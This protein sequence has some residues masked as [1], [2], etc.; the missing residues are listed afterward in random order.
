MAS[1]EFFNDINSIGNAVRSR[2][3]T[4]LINALGEQ[5]SLDSAPG[6]EQASDGSLPRDGSWVRQS[7][8]TYQTPLDERRTGVLLAP[9]DRYNRSFSTAILK[10]TDSS[11]GGN[12]MINPPPQ[13][14][15]Y[16][17]IH[18]PRLAGDTPEVG[19]HTPKN[20]QTLGQGRYYSESI[21][22]NSQ[23][24][25]M[26]FGIATFTSLTTFF[27]GFYSGNL[28]AMARGARFT[29]DFVTKWAT[30]VGNVI[31]L[32]ISPLFIVPIAIMMLGSMARFFM[33][34]PSSKFYTLKPAMPLYWN[35]VT[36]IVNQLAV[37]SGLS[38]Q[39][40]TDTAK[41]LLKGGTGTTDLKRNE[42]MNVVGQF[43][44]KGLL[45]NDGSINVYSIANRTNRMEMQYQKRLAEAF[46]NAAPD[47]SWFDVV[48][49][50]IAANPLDNFSD[51]APNFQNYMSRF[52]NFLSFNKVTST[53]DAKNATFEKDV[54]AK[55]Y[56]EKGDRYNGEAATPPGWSD[57]FV[58]N[59]NDGSEWVSYRVDYTGPA[60]EHFDNSVTE[61]S[62]ASK[63]NSM[64]RSSRD[65]RFNLA[66]GN[67]G[68]IGVDQVISA[69]R[70]VVS[71]IAET[72]HVEGLFALAGSAF[73]DIPKH[74]NE[75]SGSLNKSNY[76]ITL[77]SPYGNP[78]SRLFNIWLPLATLLAGALPLATGKQSHTS[79]FL[80]EL[81]DR[82]RSISRLAIVDSMTITRGTSNLGFD[83]EGNAMAIEVSFSVLDLSSVVAMPIHAGFDI[84]NP[85]EGLFDDANAF[86]DYLM[87]LS[88]MKLTDTIHR[89]PLLKYQIN[90]K[91]AD[92]NSY[93]S[94]AHIGSYLSSMPGVQLL[95]AAM[96]G[97][98]RQ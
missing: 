23:V 3:G 54:K 30:R 83:R 95:G 11:P 6:R 94:A 55:G 32:A 90:K 26:R 19:V 37:N 73:V 77:I 66:D 43:L 96:K 65:T 85:L 38:S 12:K 84:L 27:T 4:L 68:V 97:T 35:A 57:Y 51:D 34:S 88:G 79:P 20:H 53:E 41:L 91:L 17:D 82:G 25:H 40:N 47:A 70:G 98:D 50:A 60:S 2:D 61:S 36:S 62:L 87:T 69:V 49:R 93:F 42:I 15:R 86:T 46:A 52:F 18:P 29:D 67:T 56:N 72:V 48:R 39:V 24:I 64:S 76:N 89:V 14:T 9:Q 10:Y 33:N 13:F 16:A 8:I 31:G 7:F 22:D 74:W 92:M 58:A 81:H 75:S 80:V 78:V 1:T 59:A 44:P 71:G 63:I 5:I 21:D 45:Q 28:A